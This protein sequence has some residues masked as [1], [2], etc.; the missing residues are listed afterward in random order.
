MSKLFKNP[1]RDLSKFVVFSD[2]DVF[3]ST[4]EFTSILT[5]SG[6]AADSD[7]AGGVLV[8]AASD[9]SV[10][11]NDQTLLKTTQE[12]FK[13]AN[14]KPIVVE[15]SLQF[16]E[17]NTDDANVFFGLQDAIAADCIL[18]NGG[19]IKTAGDGYVIYKKD[20]GTKWICHSHVNGGAAT[21]TTS[22]VTAGGSA[23]QKL[24]IEIKPYSAS[25][26]NV[27]FYIDGVHV[28]SHNQS[29]ASSTEMHLGCGV[30]NGDTNLETLN[31]D[32]IYGE[33]LR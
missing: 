8:M 20:G 6:T 7:A 11:D 23:Y 5:D 24:R 3:V 13:V 19:G 14:N 32:Y 33:Q 16:S 17:A 31:V 9:G 25:Y 12:V 27:A 30:K 2:F 1:E 22:T 21:E 26:A 29:Y 28:A 4:D 18:D 15:A 10:G